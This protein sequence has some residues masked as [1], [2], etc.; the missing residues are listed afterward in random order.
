MVAP[1]KRKNTIEQTGFMLTSSGFKYAGRH[2]TDADVLAIRSYR[3]IH[4]THYVMIATYEHDPAISFI[5]TLKDGTEAQVTE[6][7]TW[8]YSSKQDRVN[9]LQADLDEICK[10]TFNQR[11][12][13]YTAQLES[14]GFYQYGVWRFFPQ[15]Q[16]FSDT[17]SGRTFTVSETKLLL[18]YGFV[19]VQE[20]SEGLAAKLFRRAKEETVGGRYGI[21][22]L[23][24]GDVFFA[25]LDHFFHIRW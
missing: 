6:Q 12:R 18:H 15:Q 20:R 13:K 25:L 21:P 5:L 11:V 2:Y 10:R 1:L 3:V 22:T 8:T 4:R 17:T 23:E 19:E 9:R 24:D 16:R 14:L 7:S